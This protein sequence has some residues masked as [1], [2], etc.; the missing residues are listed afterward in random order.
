MTT[1]AGSG[2]PCGAVSQ[3]FFLPREFSSHERLLFLLHSRLLIE[4]VVIKSWWSLKRDAFCDY[5][6]CNRISFRARTRVRRLVVQSRSACLC[7]CA[8]RGVPVSYCHLLIFPLELSRLAC[9]DNDSTS[10]RF[11]LNTFFSFFCVW[12]VCVFLVYC[13][14]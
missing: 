14:F 8:G 5:C 9:F 12:C 6:I 13:L 3:S 7:L 10:E 11:V 2:W 4:I 1:G